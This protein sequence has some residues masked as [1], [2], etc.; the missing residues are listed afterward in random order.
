MDEEVA[1]FTM[2]LTRRRHQRLGTGSLVGPFVVM[3][4]QDREPVSLFIGKASRSVCPSSE[5]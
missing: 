3:N 1:G 2:V 5:S 4:D